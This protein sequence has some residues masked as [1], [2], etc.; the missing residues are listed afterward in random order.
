MSVANTGVHLRALSSATSA[1]SRVVAYR[2][3]GIASKLNSA[4]ANPFAESRP[5]NPARRGQL[6]EVAIGVEE[7]QDR[8]DER[9]DEQEVRGDAARPRHQ[10]VGIARRIANPVTEPSSLVRGGRLVATATKPAPTSR[11]R[12]VD[13]RGR[14]ER[15]RKGGEHEQR[16]DA[17][18]GVRRGARGEAERGRPGQPRQCAAPS[19]SMRSAEADEQE[20][21]GDADRGRA[22]WHDLCGEQACGGEGQG[23]PK[24]GGGVDRRAGR[25]RYRPRRGLLR[26]R[27]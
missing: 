5:A 22:G 17:V 15:D 23:D 10:S 4:A 16:A 13:Q 21:H 11:W 24:D 19:A 20:A 9:T 14:R 27:C 6:G 25:I 7:L 18:V 12:A 8:R 26:R 2:P 3:V 1:A